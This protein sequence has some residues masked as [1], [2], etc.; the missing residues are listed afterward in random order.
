[1]EST[2][3]DS[4]SGEP[5][6]ERLFTGYTG[7]MCVVLTLGAASFK[8]TRYVVSPL[9]PTIIADL[10]ITS[11]EAGVAITSL[12]AVAAVVQY[13]GGRYS[14]RLSRK[15]VLVASLVVG[16]F[17]ALLLSWSPVY[18]AL[19]LG[20][21]LA[22]LGEGMYTPAARAQL[23]DLFLR[24]RGQAFGVYMTNVDI[25]GIAAGGLAI[26]V[27]ALA[28][29][30]LAFVV[31]LA[32]LLVV[33][34]STH[35][36]NDESYLFG[37][38]PLGI[39]ST[40]GRLFGKPR[41]RVMIAA[42]SLFMFVV[43]GV[44]GFLPTLLQ[45]DRG[46]SASLASTV[47]AMLFGVG[48]VVKPFAGRLSDVGSRLLVAAGSLTV[49]AAGIGTIALTDSIPLAIAGVAVLAV[50]QKA[51]GPVM[52]AHLMDSF[53][54]GSLGGD[55]GATRT[56][57]LG[58]GSLGPTYVGFVASWASYTWAFVGLAASTLAAALLLVYLVVTAS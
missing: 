31:V 48:L 58:A 44:F 27:L 11:V 28:T 25:G 2:E 26:G 4:A 24:R 52:Q 29:W 39:R 7:R 12:L 49:A 15:T 55:L 47:F 42:Y 10:R 9:L 56:V 45:V 37:T 32:P 35:L 51:Y 43:Q 5:S 18:V 13:P 20:T 50:G 53:P 23:S 1:M 57:Y 22:G 3:F 17:G 16:V 19:L 46:F 6:P 54:D 34:V 36:L 40:V 21:V 14:D 30:R 41:F 8:V 38:V 33:L